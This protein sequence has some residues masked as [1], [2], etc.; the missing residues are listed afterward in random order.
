M[1]YVD[2]D[3]LAVA[4]SEHNAILTH[5]SGTGGASFV[6]DVALPYKE[7][8]YGLVLWNVPGKAG[9]DVI[10]GLLD[11]VIDILAVGG[12]LAA[13]IVHPLADLFTDQFDRADA[14]IAHVER[15]KDHTV[16]HIR[17]ERGKVIERH[18][19]EEGTFDRAAQRFE[20]GGLSWTLTP[21]VGLPEYDSLDHATDLAVRAMQGLERASIDRWLIIEPG[22]GHLAVAASLLWPEATGE[23]RSRDALEVL[24]TRRAMGSNSH[25][26]CSVAW[27]I[28]V[29]DVEAP[30]DLAVVA[31]AEQAPAE[32]IERVVYRLEALV[33]PGGAVVVHGRSTEVARLERVLRRSR[34]WRHGKPRK[35]RGSAC[36]TAR[37]RQ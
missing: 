8:G 21:V 31:L 17:R 33:E 11:A 12:V 6:C 5:G 29:V 28:D 20:V 1:A 9:R 14:S 34:S 23:V 30:V 15:G 26:G 36:M 32:E 18:P 10:A 13:V 3:A 19:F 2:R 16:V 24:A 27:G 25:V 37:H 4:F 22:V 35:M 7:T